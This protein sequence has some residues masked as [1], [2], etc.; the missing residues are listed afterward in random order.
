MHKNFGEWYREVSLPCTDESLRKRWA[1]IESWVKSIFGNDEALFETVRIFRGLPER[2]SREEFLEAFRKQ[3]ATF[4]HRDN[5]HEQQVLAGA[6]LVH[7][8][9]VYKKMDEEGRV[10]TVVLVAT[11]VEASGLSAVG[12]SKTLVE[13]ANEVRTGLHSIAQELRRRRKFETILLNSEEESVFKQ[14]IATNVGDHI[15]L[16]ASFEKAFQTLL[17]AVNRSETA[18]DNAAHGLRCADEETNIL[19]WL[20]GGSSKDLH[21]PWSTL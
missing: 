12:I 5:T 15:L 10:R 14:T 3:D 21:M 20:A 19:W 16:R 1:G 18:L 9:S 2:T 17:N 13:L 8:L 6:A 11:A 7:C 4:A